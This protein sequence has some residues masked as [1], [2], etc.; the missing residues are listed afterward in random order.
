MAWGLGPGLRVVGTL[1]A[2]LSQEGPG[3]SHH[4]AFHLQ[5]GL[6]FRWFPGAEA[7]PSLASHGVPSTCT[8]AAHCSRRGCSSCVPVPWAVWPLPRR[9]P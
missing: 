6:G 1:S 9:C 3:S 7:G 8:P 2:S 4:Q 5:G